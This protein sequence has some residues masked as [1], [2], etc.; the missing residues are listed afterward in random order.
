MMLVRL[1]A[2]PHKRRCGI[3]AK[4]VSVASGPYG[5]S[6]RQRMGG[7]AAFMNVC[8]F[9]VQA[10]GRDFGSCGP[11]CCRACEA[12]SGTKVGSEAACFP[13]W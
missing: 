1:V 5:G 9:R 12:P 6:G 10:G 13:A 2:E 3:G 8:S 11:G 7:W 4:C